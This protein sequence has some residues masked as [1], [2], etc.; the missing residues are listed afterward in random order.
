MYLAVSTRPDIAFAVNFMSQFN[1]NYAEEHWKSAKRILRYLKST[2]NFG[3]LYKKTGAEFYG[4]ADADWGAN[5]TDRRSYSGFA[6]M[7]AG[8]SISWEA[9]KQRTVSLSSTEAEYLAITEAAKE[10]LYLKGALNEVG[11]EC[12]SI[13]LYN[14]NQS[15]QKLATSFNFRPRTKH[16]DVRHHFIRDCVQNNIIKLQYMPTESMPADVLTKAL[17]Q[18]K[19]IS[20]SS[21]LGLTNHNALN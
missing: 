3:L 14:D 16:I 11:I 10:A 7:F 18:A 13:K 19:H 17:T 8:S 12:A 9:R 15:A 21:N 6:F 1:S 4:V 2:I 5:T 20:C